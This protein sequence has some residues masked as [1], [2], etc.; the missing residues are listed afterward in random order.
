MN[1]EVRGGGGTG[2]VVL[3]L[4]EQLWLDSGLTTAGRPRGAADVAV[5]A[6]EGLAVVANLVDVGE[7]MAKMPSFASALR[8]WVFHSRRT[9]RRLRLEGPDISFDLP[10]P[11]N[12]ST[13]DIMR[14][15]HSL[16]ETDS[17]DD[18]VIELG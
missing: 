15:V 14:A 7:L 8:S 6:V 17:D 10:L 12:V 13:A 16:L 3:Q 5:I 2:Q 1:A 11:P 18:E 4:T 9:D